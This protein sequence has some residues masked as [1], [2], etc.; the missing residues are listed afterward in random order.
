MV[1]AGLDRCDGINDVHA[2][3]DLAEY[4]VT[5][6][7]ATVIQKIVVAQIDEKLRCCAIDLARSRH[8]QRAA[9]IA[10]AIIG[11]VRDRIA[12]RFGGHFFIHAAALN[13]E[14][15]DDTVKDCAV[16][17]SVGDVLAEIFARNWRFVLEQLDTDVAV[18]SLDCDHDVSLVLSVRL[19]T[20]PASHCH[21][22]PA[23]KIIMACDLSPSGLVEDARNG[24]LLVRAV[25][26]HQ[27]PVFNQ[28]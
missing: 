13:H 26:H 28:Q 22:G 16:E 11:L 23:G 2:I 21:A 19:F 1:G 12:G 5:E 9:V 18:I 20:I 14:I 4:G 8:G 3:A 10:L 15:R 17:M 25:L 7:A 27:R 6:I 24:L